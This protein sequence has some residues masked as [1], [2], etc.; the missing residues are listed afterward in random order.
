MDQSPQCS[1]RRNAGSPL[2]NDGAGSG[3]GEIRRYVLENDL[4][5][6][7]IGLPTDMFYHIGMSSG[8]QATGTTLRGS[9][10]I[11]GRCVRS[12]V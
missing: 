4:V 1:P 3:E 11:A 7:I 9:L 8:L 10:P 6:A 2:F 5:E 12:A